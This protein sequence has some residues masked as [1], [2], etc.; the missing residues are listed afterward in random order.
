ME[1]SAA[2]GLGLLSTV[3]VTIIYMLVFPD[4]FFFTD[5]S[6]TKKQK[7]KPKPTFEV[8]ASFLQIFFF[9]YT[10]LQ[11]QKDAFASSSRHTLVFISIGSRSCVGSSN[12]F[13]HLPPYF[14]NKF[15]I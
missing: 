12:F 10:N 14:I 8:S 1:Q 3:I 15:A 6:R 7:Q 4:F 5:C 13:L 9:T 11:G 2:L